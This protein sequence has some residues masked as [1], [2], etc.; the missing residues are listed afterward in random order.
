MA[1]VRTTVVI[2]E[3]SKES[4]AA[5]AIRAAQDGNLVWKYEGAED[6]EIEVDLVTEC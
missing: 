5:Q 3:S 1:L 6:G 2:E 4:A